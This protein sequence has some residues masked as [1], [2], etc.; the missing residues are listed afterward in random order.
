MN[1]KG[2][3]NSIFL[4]IM[5]AFF[6]PN[7]NYVGQVNIVKDLEMFS[8]DVV[9]SVDNV[10]ADALA[11]TSYSDCN[12]SSKL[13]YN[14]KVENYLNLYFQEINNLSSINCN[15]SDFS[16]NLNSSNYT[17]SIKIA[18]SYSGELVSDLSLSRTLN[19]SKEISNNYISPLCNQIIKD[20]F[21]NDSI[22][23]ELIR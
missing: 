15:Y 8:T 1:Q 21:D 23:L 10:I 19:F 20:N 4:L 22:Q 13:D 17:G 18:C 16:A 7:V 14:L 11:D 3:F 5:L 2:L 12:I 6:V 9:I